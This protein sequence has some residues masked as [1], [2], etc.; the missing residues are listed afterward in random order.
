MGYLMSAGV[1]PGGLNPIYG[2]SL[3]KKFGIPAMLY[4]CELWWN[5]TAK[6]TEQLNRCNA[7]VAKRAQGLPPRTHTAGAIGTFGY[8]Q[9]LHLLTSPN[10]CFL[11][12]F[13][14]HPRIFCIN[15][16]LFIDFFYICLTKMKK[17]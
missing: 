9:Q 7:F 13:A 3:W 1:R 17:H 16:Y 12:P 5:L 6:D 14:A 8:G 15:R 4:G 11:D 10:F 2:A